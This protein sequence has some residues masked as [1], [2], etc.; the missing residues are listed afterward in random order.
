[1]WTQAKIPLGAMR[2]LSSDEVNVRKY[3]LPLQAKCRR[4]QQD[5]DVGSNQQAPRR[6]AKAPSEQRS[7]ASVPSD[8]END[9]EDA[10]ES[11]DEGEGVIT[12]VTPDVAQGLTTALNVNVML[13][14]QQS[15]L[16]SVKMLRDHLRAEEPH[17]ATWQIVLDSYRLALAHWK[18][19]YTPGDSVFLDKTAIS[20]S[21][22][23]SGYHG[24]LLNVVSAA[25]LVLLM[26]SLLMVGEEKDPT[27][28]LGLLRALDHDFP[29]CVMSP[30]SAH[31]ESYQAYG[32]FDRA[33]DILFL[34]SEDGTA[35][36]LDMSA[37]PGV[38]FQ[39]IYD[40]QLAADPT[41][42]T[43]E[44]QRSARRSIVERLEAIGA[45]IEDGEVD[46]DAI[47]AKFPIEPFFD[48]LS[49][50][51]DNLYISVME[52]IEKIP[53]RA[54][55]VEDVITSA[56]E[57]QLQRET[58]DHPGPATGARASRG[59][60][61]P[62]RA[63][64]TVVA[65]PDTA[66]HSRKRPRTRPEP[67]IEEEQAY[68]TGDAPSNQ[69]LGEDDAT[70]PE[71]RTFK[72]PKR[73]KPRA[74]PPQSSGAHA[75][76]VDAFNAPSQNPPTSISELLPDRSR[77]DTRAVIELI[78]QHGSFWA[79]MEQKSVSNKLF[80]TPRTQQQIR[81][82]A[83]NIK[84]D[85]LRHDNVLPA[86]FDNVLLGAKDRLALRKAGK[87]QTAPRRM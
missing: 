47:Q 20:Q 13:A 29:W 11:D 18:P 86:R 63:R 28:I 7:I 77:S 52:T 32:T 10:E 54:A 65:E 19:H 6:G 21:L 49:E 76:P 43:E 26:D 46:I 48:R 41:M 83:R 5:G 66:R 34:G 27:E 38:E 56:I 60:A 61:G 36:Q 51:S 68:A 4:P 79:K 69:V 74:V 9:S 23:A 85:L 8:P 15:L 58:E 62:A 25:N 67:E 1:M 55:P 78:A 75:G 71:E 2:V 53:A 81:D 31:M 33:L 45:H 24:D 30:D 73:R 72:S 50:W 42:D 40:I 64:G 12:R 22:T 59:Q 35:R 16:T 39:P 14:L 82:K 57:Q 37:L 70:E 17:D 80:S 44:D 3:K 84:V 87:T